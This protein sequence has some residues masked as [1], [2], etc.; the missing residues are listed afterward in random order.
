MVDEEFY[1]VAETNLILKP[2]KT[3][4]LLGPVT[5]T[6]MYR[7]DKTDIVC[8]GSTIRINFPRGHVDADMR[9]IVSAA[10]ELYETHL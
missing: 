7:G 6:F 8:S 1:S 9:D 3:T 4:I 10:I 5:G 2:K